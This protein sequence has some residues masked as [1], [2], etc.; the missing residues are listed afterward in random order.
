MKAHIYSTILVFIL[1]FTS[2]SKE[3]LDVKN[4]Q[5]LYRES[6]VKDLTTM[7]DYLR[8]IYL[9]LAVF[10]FESGEIESSYSEL[11]ADNLRAVSTTS[12]V[13]TRPIYNWTQKNNS[14][15][16]QIW[17]NGYAT[18]RMCNFVIE[19]V[20]KF[21]NENQ[22]KAENM[23]GQAFAL[24]AMIHFKLVNVFGQHYTYTA[25]A[26]HYGVPYITTSDITQPYTRITVARV[27][28]EMI[29][30]LN[31]AIGLLPT[32]VSD[33]RFMNKQAAK[34]LLAR[35]Y[36]FKEDYIKAKA[37]AKEVA[38][39]V[40]LM[41]IGAGYPDDI[42]KWKS[43]ETTETLFQLSPNSIY[44]Q[45]LGIYLRGSLIKF[46]ATD[47]I[48]NSLTENLEDVRFNWIKDS[49]ISGN[50]VRLIKKFPAGVAPELPE[51][52]AKPEV[53]YYPAILR[54]SEMFLTVA[55]AAAKTNDEALSKTYLNA[56]RK[57]A[58]LANA[59]VTATGG[60]L[61]DSIYK[62]RRKELSFEG[63]RMFD[64]QRSKRDVV[65]KDALPGS[66]TNLPYPNDRSVAPIFFTEIQLA[67]VPQNPG[68]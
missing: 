17:K 48:A 52:S 51:V 47:D 20:N 56:V 63:L 58:G 8:G 50:R 66:P 1:L 42:F 57:R 34:A 31:S 39:Q 11:V 27:Y 65:R 2:C 44:Q 3:F 30:D 46:V 62:E 37:L 38:D 49:T 29:N 10:S 19:D 40:P 43:P 67:G 32:K 22:A 5:N 23:K 60:A 59:D 13:L 21:K 16:Y 61:L 68:Y 9:R 6:Y 12:S 33:T 36:L 7:E 55:E 24:R 54:S 53:A 45:Y 41:T 35:I 18:I 4:T 26:S 64:L 25:N 28:Q 14:S 15:I